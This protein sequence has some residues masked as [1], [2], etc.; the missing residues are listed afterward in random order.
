MRPVGDGGGLD[1]LGP[2]DPREISGY[3]LEARIG[4]GGMGTVYL[5][6]TRGNRPLALKVIRREHARDPHYRRRFAQEAQAART[7]AGYHLVPVLDFDT[8]AEQPW[9]ASAYQPGLPLDS[10][11]D[12]YGPLP[13][14][15]ALQVTGC[16]ARALHA[17]HAAGY[18]HRDVKPSNAL[19]GSDGPWLIDFGIARSD[20]TTNLTVTG[21]IVG[22]PRF[23]SPEHARGQDPG[24]AADVFS[25][26]LLAAVTGSGRHPYGDGT[27]LGVA[28]LIAATDTGPP[29][30]DAYPEPLRRVLRAALAADPGERPG[31]DEL[32]ALCEELAGR[33]LTD[34]GD[35]LPPAVA[36]A[37]S[38]AEEAATVLVR[39]PRP[40]FAAPATPPLPPPSAAPSAAAVAATAG[41]PAHPPVPGPGPAPAGGFG[42]PPS[43]GTTLRADPS[44]GSRRRAKV[45]TVAVAA[46]AVAAVTVAGTLAWQADDGR[47]RDDRAGTG[48][49]ADADRTGGTG[50]AASPGQTGDGKDGARGEESGGDRPVPSAPAGYTLLFAHKPFTFAPPPSDDR[51][52]HLD[53]DVPRSTTM[54]RG[55]LPGPAELVY[56]SDGWLG[57]M[58]V[59]VGER[60][61]VCT[62]EQQ[63]AV[64]SH[65]LPAAELRLGRQVKVGTVLC[66][67]T[68]NDNVAE[69][70]ITEI[71][72]G[73]GPDG[74]PTYK[75][76]VTAWKRP[77]A[78][79]GG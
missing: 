36:A 49:E 79:P 45:L 59:V 53:F 37:V 11:L 55:A 26:G 57:S 31:A 38:S 73:V 68:S 24:P 1:P 23:M 13:V 5:S 47:S 21:G 50:P 14:P 7:V 22:T 75:G 17:V 19:I 78:G 54:E 30:L 42:P 9:I 46:L 40:P 44:A 61:T 32:A 6:R 3:P 74:L 28:A 62:E 12:R 76:Y 66:S 58:L 33:P 71:V 52:N 51:A 41:G 27:G 15:A 2:D 67:I 72:P 16:L 56:N 34:F 20:D 39:R 35:W 4:E 29:V 8:D 43:M 65:P 48:A 77:G 60:T 70:E 64:L 18:V 63:T 10:L 69:A 25:L